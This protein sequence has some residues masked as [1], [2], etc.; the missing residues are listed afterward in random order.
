MW[1]CMVP[2]VVVEQGLISSLED[3]KL[4]KTTYEEQKMM[5]WKNVNNFHYISLIR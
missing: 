1:Q 2:N 4:D 3:T 5:E